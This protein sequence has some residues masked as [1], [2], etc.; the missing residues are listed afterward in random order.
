MIS[1]RRDRGEIRECTGR[2]DWNWEAFGVQCGNL[3]QLKFPEICE[4]DLS[5]DF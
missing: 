3:E 2:D 4:D 1:Y 5:E